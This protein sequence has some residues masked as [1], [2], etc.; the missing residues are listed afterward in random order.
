MDKI[1]PMDT[2]HFVNFPCQLL[3][4]FNMKR[5]L[6]TKPDKFKQDAKEVRL[7]GTP[8]TLVLTGCKS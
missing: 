5:L 7:S 3:Y 8:K 2:Q 4:K 6:S 1:N